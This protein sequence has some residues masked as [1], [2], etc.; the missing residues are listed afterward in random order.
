MNFAL[1]MA[2]AFS[3]RVDADL[4]RAHPF[5]NERVGFLFGR[6][7]RAGVDEWLVFPSSY[8]PVPDELY[9]DEPLIGAK[10]NNVAVRNALQRALSSGESCFHVHLHSPLHPGFGDLDLREQD[11]L[12]P[13]FVALNGRVP[14]GA[15]VMF[16]SGCEARAW[17]PGAARPVL[18]RR[19]AVVGF[20]LALSRRAS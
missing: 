12:I 1:H 13:S 4:Q 8:Q 15:L 20:P 16:E 2:R 19:V 18:A 14:H 7:A 17:L 9:I 3:E 6:S 5:A 10:V 11:K